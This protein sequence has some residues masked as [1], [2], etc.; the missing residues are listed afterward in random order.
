MAGFGIEASI[1]ELLIPR[2]VGGILLQYLGGVDTHK[3]AGA[4]AV[5]D[6]KFFGILRVHLEVVQEH[7]LLQLLS[8]SFDVLNELGLRVR[9][10]EVPLYYYPIFS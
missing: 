7:I 5:A 6:E 1:E 3:V 9:L 4:V 10:S 2:L 8:G